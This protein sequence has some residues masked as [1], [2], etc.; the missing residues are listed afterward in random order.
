MSA[1]VTGES[2]EFTMNLPEG[3]TDDT[4]SVNAFGYRK[5]SISLAGIGHSLNIAL[6]Q[7]SHEI[8]E[9]QVRPQPAVYYVKE[10]IRNIPANYPSRP[11]ETV[12]FF[13]ERITE[14]KQFLKSFQAVFKTYC[15][16]YLDTVKNQD[17]LYLYKEG[18]QITQMQFLSRYR[19]K[20]ERKA[21]KKRERGDTS[22]PARPNVEVDLGEN[23]MAGPDNILRSSR[24]GTR[25]WLFLDSTLLQE[26]DYEFAGQ[27]FFDDR[28]LM[29]ISFKSDGKVD[30]LRE[31]GKIYL[32]R[33]SL[34]IVRIEDE[35]EFVI[36]V[37][38]RPVIFAF[39]FGVSN[40]QIKRNVE[41]RQ[42]GNKWYP[43]KIQMYA[44]ARLVRRYM[45]APNE[46]SF[47]EVNQLYA[48]TNLNVTDPLPV[49]LSKRYT[50]SKKMEEQAY[51]DAGLSW[52]DINEVRD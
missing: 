17:Q 19:D 30:N 20:K 3:L 13:R 14:N 32:D 21:E 50:S 41:F 18:E 16:S 12:A 31:S 37:A 10:A 47:M 28:E 48:V 34:A 52:D 9:V 15:P 11:F 2:G 46:K 38:L 24:I 51:N 33:E 23:K 45:F 44:S 8:E 6:E 43:Q 36:P 25:F 27:S 22:A 1:T 7:V 42:V 35:G 26:Y 49:P 40:P 4:L 29:V 39:G 5:T